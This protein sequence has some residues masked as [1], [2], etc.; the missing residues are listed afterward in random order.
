[1][2]LMMIKQHQQPA[3]PTAA[4]AT[5]T[6]EMTNKMQKKHLACSIYLSLCL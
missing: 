2:K 1:M 6:V 5:T 3:T 4:E